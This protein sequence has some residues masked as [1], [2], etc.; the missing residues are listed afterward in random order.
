VIHLTTTDFYP[1][2]LVNVPFD[3]DIKIV[4]FSNFSIK[5]T[6]FPQ[7]VRLARGS[8]LPRGSLDQNGLTPEIEPID[9]HSAS[10]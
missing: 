9:S 5:S 2:S 3:E 6:R 10:R 7:H 8:R 4:G 1:N